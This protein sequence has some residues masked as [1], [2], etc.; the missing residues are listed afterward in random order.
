MRTIDEKNLNISTIIA[1]MLIPLSG[2][3]TDVYLPSFPEMAEVFHTT[4]EGIQ[5]TLVC[6]LISYG[7][8]QVIVG[9]ILDSVGRYKITLISLLIFSLSNF[10]IIITRQIEIVYIMRVIQGVTIAFILVGKR[11]FFVDVYEGEKRKSYT[12]TQTIVWSTA[13]IVAPFLGGYLQTHFGWTSSFYFLGILSFILFLLELF[14]SGESLKQFQSFN[15][16]KSLTSYKKILR[17][18]DFT[19][20]VLSLGALFSMVILFNMTI[21]FIVEKKFHFSPIITGYCALLSGMAIFIGGFIGKALKD[22]SIFKQLICGNIFL[23]I[24]IATM[25]F[26]SSV[27]DKLLILMVF[28]VLLHLIEG[29]LFNRFFTHCVMRFPEHAGM[30]SGIVGGGLYLI[31]SGATSST[32]DFIAVSGQQSLAMCYLVFTVLVTILT[33]SIKFLPEAYTQYK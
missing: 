3:A 8:T 17:T 22:G 18:A 19:I 6:F 5:L 30:A 27:S 13:P 20:G 31:T 26:T 21:P 33:W 2:L 11:V 9:S 4:P 32:L 16:M 23:Y 10:L 28:V 15:F 14:Y 25:Y 7:L 1:F 12:A 24:I 29:T